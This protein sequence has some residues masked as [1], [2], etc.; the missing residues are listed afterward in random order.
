MEACIKESCTVK[1]SANA[2][3]LSECRVKRIKG[4]KR[5]WRKIHSEIVVENL[6]T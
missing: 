6:K 2:L 1:Q 4:G 3:G 5:K